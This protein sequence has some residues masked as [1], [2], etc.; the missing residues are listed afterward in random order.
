MTDDRD[1]GDVIKQ[2]TATDLMIIKGENSELPKMGV[3]FKMPHD[4]DASKLPKVREDFRLPDVGVH[5]KTLDVGE[6]LK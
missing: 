4:K 5:L 3:D 1:N 2:T 6:T